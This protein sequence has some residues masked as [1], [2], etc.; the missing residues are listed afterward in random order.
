MADRVSPEVRSRIMSAIKGKNTKA[1]LMVFREL[2]RRR[3]SFQKHHKRTLGKP[4]ICFPR[5]K[6]AVFVD[7]DFWHGYRYPVWK[8]RLGS[9][10][11]RQK[12]ERNISRDRRNFAKLR[13]N[14]WKVLR[15]WEH[16]LYGD[17]ESSVDRIEFLIK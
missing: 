12:I 6:V 14:G 11:W 13:R 17:L 4:D 7:G 3:I 1:E 15:L 10:Y 9:D 2:R 16:Q 5:K 8:D